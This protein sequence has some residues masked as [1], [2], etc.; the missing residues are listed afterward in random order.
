MRILLD[1]HILLAAAADCVPQKAAG[2]I[3]DTANTPVFSSASIW[4]I[5]IKC[6]LH[7]ADFM[8]DPVSLYSG[9]LGAGYEE[10][11]VTA[12]HTLLV[13]TLPDLHKDPFDRILLAQAIS[14][15]IPLLT[16]DAILAEYPGSV[17]FA[18]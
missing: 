5:V 9:L 16:S 7:R 11:P 14:E 8:V 2:Y 1:T 6:G 15:G 13:S 10:L 3:E 18:G 12:R 17:I 4:E